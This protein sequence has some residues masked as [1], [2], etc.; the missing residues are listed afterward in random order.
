MQRSS[1]QVSVSNSP[2]QFFLIF[3]PGLD[4]NRL[5]RQKSEGRRECKRHRLSARLNAAS[6]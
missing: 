1:L 3:P 5:R 4:E 2:Q 6:R